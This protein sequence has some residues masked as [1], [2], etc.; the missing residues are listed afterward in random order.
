[1]TQPVRSGLPFRS[2]EPFPLVPHLPSFIPPGVLLSLL[3]RA[4]TR[5]LPSGHALDPYS[6]AELMPAH[7]TELVA[8]P[9]VHSLTSRQGSIWYTMY[10]CFTIFYNCT[11]VYVI[12]GASPTQIAS[13]VKADS[14][15]FLF[16]CLLFVSSAPDTVPETS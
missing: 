14:L 12:L 3:L 4:G 5:S 16:A 9:P 15:S 6:F 2:Q 7:T 1:M 10:L 13:S 8:V 11:F